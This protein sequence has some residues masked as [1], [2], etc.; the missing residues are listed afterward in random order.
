MRTLPSV[1]A[2]LALSA[3]VLSLAACS[4]DPDAT[5]EADAAPDAPLALDGATKP[6]ANGPSDAGPLDATPT[7]TPP[8]DAGPS[9]GRFTAKPLGSTS[10]PNG[11]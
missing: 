8:A 6:D 3:V 7:W 1:A 9:S 4:A 5:P 10:A 2:A 11:F